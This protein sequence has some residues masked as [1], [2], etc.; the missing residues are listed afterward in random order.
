MRWAL[1]N[2]A[3]FNTYLIQAFYWAAG[4]LYIYWQG[5]EGPDGYADPD[6]ENYLR[7]CHAAGVRPVEEVDACGEG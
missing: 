3:H 4:K 1:I 2:S 7:L 5:E 6:R